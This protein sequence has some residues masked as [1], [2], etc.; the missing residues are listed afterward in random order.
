M[1]EKIDPFKPSAG[2][3]VKLGSIA[4]HAEEMMSPSGHA[5]DRFALDALLGDPEVA[6]WL[7]A[8]DSMALLP[9]KR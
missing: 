7:A 3:L 5:V 2:L 4:V 9:V 1:T 8:M 6:N